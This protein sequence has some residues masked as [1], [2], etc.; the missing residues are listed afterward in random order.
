MSAREPFGKGLPS[1][2]LSGHLPI[3]N[4]LKLDVMTSTNLCLVF[5]FLS[6]LTFSTLPKYPLAYQIHLLSMLPH[7][8]TSR[9][10]YLVHGTA[11][12]WIQPGMVKACIDSWSCWRDD[13]LGS[14]CLTMPQNFARWRFAWEASTPMN[15]LK[16]IGLKA[17]YMNAN[18]SCGKMKPWSQSCTPNGSHAP[19]S[20]VELPFDTK[21]HEPF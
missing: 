9:L 6:A 11:S 14:S 20:V 10:S 12:P 7:E 15:T 8:Q 17:V 1:Q 16:K 13:R 18:H 5:F 19:Q 3:V 2:S 21:D 4:A